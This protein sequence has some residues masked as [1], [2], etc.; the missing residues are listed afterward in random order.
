[1]S[2]NTEAQERI[3]WLAD[4]LL[5]GNPGQHALREAAFL[6]QDKYLEASESP[7]A[8]PAA[9]AEPDIADIVAGALQTSRGNAYELLREALALSDEPSAFL[10]EPLPG[11]HHALMVDV[12]RFH[13][14]YR[15][16]WTVTPLYAAA[17]TPAAQAGDELPPLPDELGFID[18]DG[19]CHVPF[20]NG[21]TADIY[22]ADQ[23]RAYA[24]AARG[25]Q[26]EPWISVEDRLPEKET[27]VLV[28]DARGIAIA[29]IFH[30]QWQSVHRPWQGLDVTHW[31]PLPAAPRA[32]LEAGRAAI[33]AA[34]QEQ[35][36]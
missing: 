2:D 12:V 29:G 13:P 27:D 21:R 7:A 33:D 30:G 36:T 3:R 10:I 20:Y 1:M 35:P 17:P 19:E 24:L 31:Q 34:T 22:T 16:D 32:A 6:L 14:G 28:F 8:P 15:P 18:A 23:M 11:A 4:E 25:A 5:R 9:Q 26:A